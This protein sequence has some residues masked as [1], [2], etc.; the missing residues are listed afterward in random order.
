MLVF[1]KWDNDAVCTKSDTQSHSP[2][3]FLRNSFVPVSGSRSSVPPSSFLSASMSFQPRNTEVSGKETYSD[4]LAKA[5][6]ANASSWARQFTVTEEAEEEGGE[7]K[8]KKAYVGIEKEVVAMEVAMKQKEE[9]KRA[10]LSSLKK[11]EAEISSLSKSIDSRKKAVIFFLC[12]NF[13]S[14]FSQ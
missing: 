8:K 1:S 10:M 2:P 14:P 5:T 3:L 6:Q 4:S 12:L 11:I 13:L 7:G 9:A